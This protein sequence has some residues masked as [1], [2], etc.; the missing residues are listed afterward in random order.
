MRLVGGEVGDGR[1]EH[2]GQ[3][4]RA[5]VGFGRRRRHSQRDFVFGEAC[6]RKASK[7]DGHGAG[8]H[9]AA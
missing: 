7:A 5:L 8:K 4:D 1:R 6:G 9:Q 2:L 3:R